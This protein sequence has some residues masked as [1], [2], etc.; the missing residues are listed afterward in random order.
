MQ[1]AERILDQGGVADRTAD[2][3][4]SAVLLEPDV[5]DMLGAA[6]GPLDSIY[7]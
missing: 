6:A 4:L 3:P 2:D 1:V 7:K 5:L